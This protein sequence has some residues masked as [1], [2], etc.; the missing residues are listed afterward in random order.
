MFGL[1]RKKSYPLLKNEMITPIDHPITTTEAKKLYKSYMKDIGFL[2]KDELSENAAYFGEEIRDMEQ[3]YKEDI[4]ES[5]E[6]IKEAKVTIKE[7]KQQ[8]KSCD[9]EEL[10]VDLQ[11]QLENLQD[12]I[13]WEVEQIEKLEMELN[14]FKKDKRAF[15]IEYVNNQISNSN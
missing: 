5:K 2:E 3:T 6:T 7:I 14:E 13:D 10:K 12:E 1:F 11:D 8:L 15:L 4:K 9:S